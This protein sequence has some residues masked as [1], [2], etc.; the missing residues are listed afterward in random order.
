MDQTMLAKSSLAIFL[1]FLKSLRTPRFLDLYNLSIFLSAS[2]AWGAPMQLRGAG[3]GAGSPDI[4][5]PVRAR[6]PPRPLTPPTHPVWSK[7]RMVRAETNNPWCSS[8]RGSSSSSPR[9]TIMFLPTMLLLLFLVSSLCPACLH[10]CR[11]AKTCEIFKKKEEGEF[12]ESLACRCS[13][14]AALAASP[15][16]CTVHLWHCSLFTSPV[17]LYTALHCAPV[18]LCTVHLTCDTVTQFLLLLH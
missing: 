5:A 7:V 17:T 11:N 15:H 8:C 3:R 18:T 14:P 16:L 13:R 4:P 1:L 9:L 10:W 2:G 12:S 6:P